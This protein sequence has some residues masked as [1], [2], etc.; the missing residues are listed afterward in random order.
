MKISEYY[1]LGATQSSLDFVDIDIQNDVKVF[2][3]PTALK[4]LPS[5]WGNECVSLIQNYFQTVLDA[6]HENRGQD[7]KNILRVLHEPNETHLGLSRNQ[8]KGK[9]LGN[10]LA[11]EVFSSLNTS[12][13]I[14]SG[15]LEDLEDTI[16][17]IE[18]IG[19]DIISDITTN[20]IRGPLIRYTQ[21]VFKELNI[22]LNED[23]DS[24]PIWN[25]N[26]KEWNQE[27]V[28][29]PVINN[30][31]I[32]LVPKVI[33]R[34]RIE[35][36]QGEYYRHYLLEYLKEVEISANTALVKL[37]KDGRRIVTKKSLIEKYGTGKSVIVSQTRQYPEIL[38]RYKEAKDR[39]PE[40]PLTHEEISEMTG[41]PQPDWDELLRKVIEKVPGTN[42]AYEYEVAVEHLL[43]ALLYPSLSYP[44]LQHQ[45]HEGR[46]RI[47]IQYTNVA[48]DK[49]FFAWLS[50]NYSAPHVFVECKNYSTDVSNPELDQLSGRFS[51]SRGQFG[52]IVCRSFEDKDSFIQRCKDTSID[53]RGFI[54][55]LDDGDLSELV[56]AYK[57][58]DETLKFNFFK[59]RFDKL[60]M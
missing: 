51:P 59:S 36:D 24:G 57:S 32:L 50:H 19:P 53:Q 21:N 25:P 52:I 45:I 10:I 1:N 49:G 16:L 7:A 28:K 33:V 5:E 9:A 56:N 31:R 34:R 20:I 46:K 22:V 29:L 27:F 37:L 42:D 12:E 2:V 41:T 4:L 47:D 23:V 58:N 6:I 30:K 11:D 35:Y 8:A 17:M 15:L 54:L 13:A 38:K 43:T 18:G 40:Q 26:T 39:H 3:D 55:A 44:I 48:I 14:R 60:I